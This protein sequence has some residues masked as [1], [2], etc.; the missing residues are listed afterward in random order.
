MGTAWDLRDIPDLTGRTVLVTGANAGLGLEITRI[1]AGNGARVLMACRNPA[2]AEAAAADVLDTGPRGTVE[3]RALDLASIASVDALAAR[4]RAEE[5][6]LHLLVNNAG[7]MAVDESRTEDGFE[8]QLG[9]NHLGH[10]ALTAGLVPVLLATP[11]SRVVSMS[12]MGHRAGRMRF[13]DLNAQRRPYR[14]WQAYFQSKLA[15]LLFTLELQRR[16]GPD[17]PTQALA[18]HPGGSRTE[19]G[20]EGGGLFNAV[21]RAPIGAFLQSAHA[22]ALPAVRA[23][24]DPDAQ[25]GEYYGPRYRMIGPAVRE[26]PSRRARDVDDA[27]R[28]WELSE[29][30]TGRA[31]VLDA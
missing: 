16:L 23:G 30:M 5:S 12:S 15:N 4:I 14:R 25:G 31:F 29:E 1:L 2:K 19:L 8:M 10:F 22:G 6:A 27:R 18:A 28:L 21:M 20:M 13:D 3:V 9:V 24:V 7:L 11:G 26:T 17:A